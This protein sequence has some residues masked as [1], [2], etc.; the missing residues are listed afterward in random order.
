MLLATAFAAET[1]PTIGISLI[2]QNPDPATAGNIVELRIGVDNT[3]TTTAQD[4]SLTFV[5]SYPF[6]LVPGEDATVD[7]G[8]LSPYQQG[9][10]TSIVKYDILIDK[11]APAGSYALKI[12]YKEG[13]SATTL[14]ATLW[15]DVSSNDNAEIIYIDQVE[16]TPGKITP[17][18]FTIT[19]VGS[20]PLSDLTFTWENSDD[21]ILPV[22]SDNTRYIDHLGIGESTN[23]TYNVIASATADPDLYKLDL[24]LA[25]TD[26][27]TDET[28]TTATK[29]GV[30]VG[31]ATDF[32]V[33]Y[34]SSSSGE[35]SFSIAN[36]GSVSATSVVVKIPEQES[37]RVS[38]SDSVIIGNLN[39]GDYTIASFTL[40]QSFS[41]TAGMQTPGT[42]QANATR[43]TAAQPLK[44]DI[45][46]TDS[47]GNRQTIEKEANLA[48]S[49][50]ATT[51]TADAGTANFSPGGMG[52]FN[53]QQQSTLQSFWSNAKWL[54]IG[55]V[56]IVGIFLLRRKYKREQLIDPDYS[57][58]Q[59]FGL[60][61]KRS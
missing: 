11:N 16:L 10:D 61:K 51:Y 48:T 46:Y 42:Q 39:E 25:Y 1:T 47:R 18:T 22:G 32:D 57:L 33:A 19:N 29:A 27:M 37:W 43:T 41:R 2:N 26:P 50:A 28:H 13:D 34:S 5:P 54:V 59:L 3:G 44:I 8:S 55:I 23:L 52:G 56:L 49:S 20:S 40:E 24:E 14:Q 38:G 58:K 36:I 17:M 6:T 15:V 9:E 21:I 60:S 7:V 4:V 12:N 30:Y 31:G 35:Y 53:R 45:I